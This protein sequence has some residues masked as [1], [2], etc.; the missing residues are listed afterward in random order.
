M[1]DLKTKYLGIELKNPIVVGASN[2]VTDVDNLIKLEKAGAAAIVYKSLFEEQIQLESYQMDQEN[3]LYQDWDPEHAS[4]FPEL[5]HAGPSEHLIKLRRAKQAIGI[6]LIASLNAVLDETWVD[7]AVQLADTGVDALELNFY[8]T[9]TDASLS[10]ADIEKRQVD[11]IKSI[12]KKVKIPVSV[13]LSPY[14]TNSLKVIK[15]MDKAGADG[16]ILFNRLFQPD[17]DLDK[18]EHHYPYNFSAEGDHRLALRYAG[19]LYDE[20]KGSVCSN[21]GIFSGKDVAKMIL[22]GADSV[23]VVSAIYKKGINHV[24]KMIKELDSWMKSRKYKKLSDFRGK[25]SRKELADPFAY[26]RAQ[27]VDILM[28]SEVFMSYHPKEEEIID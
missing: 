2:I 12:K 17:I 15:D 20:I 14:Y 19:L 18:E 6:P 1:A 3:E 26:K 28:K 27:Y 16:F 4:I 7:Y 24:G 10:G 21:T 11:I 13:K 8:A 25:L 5:G 22:A 23:Q 9:V